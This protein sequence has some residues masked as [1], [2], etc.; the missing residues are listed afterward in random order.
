[1][2]DTILWALVARENVLDLD[3]YIN[4]LVTDIGTPALAQGATGQPRVT[5]STG[6][7]DL[8]YTLRSP[9]YGLIEA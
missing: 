6:L 3:Q 4:H 7:Q 9:W 2:F 1:M 8:T 5:S